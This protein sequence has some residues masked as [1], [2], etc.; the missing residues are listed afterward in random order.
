MFSVGQ[1]T[2]QGY[3][4]PC[5]DSAAW[6]ALVL[7]HSHFN[8]QAPWP[9]VEQRGAAT[10]IHGFVGTS[11]QMWLVSS[12]LRSFGWNLLCGP[13]QLQ[14]HLINMGRLVDSLMHCVWVCHRDHPLRAAHFSFVVKPYW[15]HFCLFPFLHLSELVK[16]ITDS[17]THRIT[18]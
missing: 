6:V 18:H 14:G 11:A 2:F 13:S 10:V 1:K 9:L 12:T 5:S 8:T 15:N 3:C 16:K 4:S 7:G 17:C